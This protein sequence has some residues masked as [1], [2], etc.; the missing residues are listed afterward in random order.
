MS[1]GWEAELTAAKIKQKT[2]KASYFS[3]DCFLEIGFGKLIRDSQCGLT[4][5]QRIATI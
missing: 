4:A 2:R 5:D 1:P 3:D